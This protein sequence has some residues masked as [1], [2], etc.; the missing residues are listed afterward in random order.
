M[1]NVFRLCLYQRAGQCQMSEKFPAPLVSKKHDRIYRRIVPPFH[2]KYIVKGGTQNRFRPYLQYRI[3]SVLGSFYANFLLAA[4]TTW[5]TS[6]E[7]VTLPTPP[8]TGVIASTIGSAFSKSTS[9]QSFPS[10]LTL[11]PTSITT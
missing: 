10:A 3:S 6:T 7:V 9:P 4:S 2:P 11:I 1:E 5:P 8:G